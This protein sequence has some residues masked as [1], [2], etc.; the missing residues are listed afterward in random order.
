MFSVL[1]KQYLRSAGTR[2]RAEA[3]ILPTILTRP[4]PRI[5]S[6]EKPAN[7]GS[8]EGRRSSKKGKVGTAGRDDPALRWMLEDQGRE[9]GGISFLVWMV[10]NSAPTADG[11]AL[12]L[13]PAIKVSRTGTM[14]IRYS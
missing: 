13:R 10:L 8:S 7:P 5:P 3:T 11:D 1:L 2:G 9:F 6:G 14:G 4:I 12:K